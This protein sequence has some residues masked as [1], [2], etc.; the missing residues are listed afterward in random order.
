M[1]RNYWE[2]RNQLAQIPGD[3]VRQP[4]DAQ[5]AAGGTNQGVI[6][7]RNS[8]VG[9]M[10]RQGT[11]VSSSGGAVGV[12]LAGGSGIFTPTNDVVLS[13]PDIDWSYAVVERQNKVDLTTSLIPF[14]LGKII[15]D[16]DSSQNVEL[17]SGDVVTIFSTADLKV[18]TAQQTRF[19]RLEGEFV[20]SGVYSVKPGE[21]LRQLLE[22]AGGLTPDAYL[23]ASEFTRESTRRVEQQRLNEYADQLEAL[24]SSQTATGN[25]RALT[26][27]DAA[28]ASASSTDAQVAIDR[29]RRVQPE[30]RIVLPLKPDNNSLTDIPDLALEDGDRFCVPRVPSSVSVEGQVYSANAFVYV[31]GRRV[32]DYLKEAGGPSRQADMRRAFVLRADGSVLSRQY[33][34]LEHAMV[35]PG[36][37]IVV[38]LRV[39]KKAVLR[40]LTDIATIIGNFGVGVAAVNVLK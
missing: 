39:D 1:T 25:A 2:K 31:S 6:P 4:E 14:N 5:G 33:G 9:Q 17:Q 8:A 3:Y 22:R 12:A 40:D 21:T 24:V 16:G 32:Q 23:Y 20:G 29:L 35:Y 19:V 36:D 37:T 11:S 10:P 30:G 26:D 13:A 38:P 7:G 15:L 34:N 28:A 18:P 27:R